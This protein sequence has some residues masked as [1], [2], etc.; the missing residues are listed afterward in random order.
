M[1]AAGDA[2]F[3]MIVGVASMWLLRV[4]LGYLLVLHFHTGVLGIW[5]AWILDWILRSICFIPRFRS[6]VWENRAF[7]D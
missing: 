3:S 7:R 5:C 4:C 6:H 2:R 1:R